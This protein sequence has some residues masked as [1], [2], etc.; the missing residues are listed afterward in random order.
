VCDVWST[1][2]WYKLR[3]NS[4]QGIRYRLGLNQYFVMQFLFPFSKARFP[5]SLSLES[6][7]FHRR[8]SAKQ[9][10]LLS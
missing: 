10:V 8:E 2:R 9:L 3:G 5:F 4:L 7:R 1:I 6:L